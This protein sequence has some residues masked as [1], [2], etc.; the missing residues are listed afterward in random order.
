MQF[1]INHV[2]SSWSTWLC[3]CFLRKSE[4]SPLLPIWHVFQCLS[5]FLL[6]MGWMNWDHWD[7]GES[8]CLQ[9][10]LST[11]GARTDNSSLDKSPLIGDPALAQENKCLQAAKEWKFW[12]Q[13]DPTTTHK[14]PDRL[15]RKTFICKLSSKDLPNASV[16]SQ[17]QTALCSLSEVKVMKTSICSAISATQWCHRCNTKLAAGESLPLETRV[18]GYYWLYSEGLHENSGRIMLIFRLLAENTQYFLAAASNGLT[19]QATHRFSSTW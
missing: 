15:Q 10:K 18:E 14:H 17:V 5:E 4:K 9:T 16:K 19:Q 7:R 3:A 1:N 6:V 11:T 2:H 12:A 8:E 13:C